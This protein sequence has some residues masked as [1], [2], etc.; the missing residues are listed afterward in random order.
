MAGKKQNFV[1]KVLVFAQS[2]WKEIVRFRPT[3]DV[4]KGPSWNRKGV[5][6]YPIQVDTKRECPNYEHIEGKPKRIPRPPPYFIVY[7]NIVLLK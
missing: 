3:I 5:S 4:N 1:E 2:T 7:N 6:C